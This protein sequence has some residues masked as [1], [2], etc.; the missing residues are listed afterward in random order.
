MGK[1]LL[2][3]TCIWDQPGRS[4]SS[5]QLSAGQGA[6]LDP[7][8]WECPQPPLMYFHTLGPTLTVPLTTGGRVWSTS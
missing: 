3:S 7:C 2:G 5:A 4:L 8:M 6:A 1:H